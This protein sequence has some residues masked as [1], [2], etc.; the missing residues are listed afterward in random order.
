MGQRMLKIMYQGMKIMLIRKRM[1][2]HI[3]E[4]EGPCNLNDDKQHMKIESLTPIKCI[5]LN[6]D[7][8]EEVDLNVGGNDEGV[9]IENIIDLNFDGA[10]ALL[11]TTGSLVDAEG[12]LE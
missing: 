6:A 12:L 7:G 3:I 10:W 8:D 11:A 2:D 5:D 4:E 9:K 1:Q